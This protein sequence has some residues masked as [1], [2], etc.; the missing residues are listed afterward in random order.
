MN[1]LTSAIGKSVLAVALAAGIMGG[2]GV[3]E[4]RAALSDSSMR[5]PEGTENFYFGLPL[6]SA[7]R[8]SIYAYR[9]D[10]GTWQWTDWYWVNRGSYWYWDA[11]RAQVVALPADSSMRIVPVGNNKLV[12]GWEYRYSPS[13]GSGTWV[14]LGYC[15]TTSYFGGGIIFN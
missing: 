12:E 7:P 10:G 11:N 14:N 15:R 9:I 13:T 1:V 2:T 8:W 4:A 3:Q 6:D 5:C